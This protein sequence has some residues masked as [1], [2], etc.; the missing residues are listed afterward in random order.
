M[1]KMGSANKYYILILEKLLIFDLIGFQN[2]LLKTQ[3]H[4]AVF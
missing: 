2:F 1:K 4:V 3:Q